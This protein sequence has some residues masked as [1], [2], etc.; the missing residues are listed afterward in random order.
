M[1]RVEKVSKVVYMVSSLVL[2]SER[3]TRHLTL[4]PATSKTTSKT[5]SASGSGTM[6]RFFSF[7]RLL[8]TTGNS[9]GFNEGK[10]DEMWFIL[11]DFLVLLAVVESK[12]QALRVCTMVASTEIQCDQ[13]IWRKNRPIF[14]KN[15]PKW[16]PTYYLLNKRAFLPHF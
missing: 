10:A 16:S 15:R 6:A 12:N 7:E 5:S 13:M 11:F 3:S 2:K 1:M 9:S 8:L 4:V 14:S